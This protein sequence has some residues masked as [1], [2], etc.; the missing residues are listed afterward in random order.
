MRLLSKHQEEA[1]TAVRQEK[2]YMPI[3][4]LATQWNILKAMIERGV[5]VQESIDAVVEEEVAEWQ[6]YI[7]RITRGGPWPLPVWNRKQ[8]AIVMSALAGEDWTVITQYIELLKR[9]HHVSGSTH[10]SRG[11]L[12]APSLPRRWWQCPDWKRTEFAYLASR[13]LFHFCDSR[14]LV[15]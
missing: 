9:S 7:T 8:L 14:P 2:V 6:A 15:F 4:L 11:R 13:C 5:V 1:V 3:K 12:R 10:T